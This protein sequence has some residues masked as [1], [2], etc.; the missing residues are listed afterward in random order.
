ML[1][2]VY[3]RGYQ[4]QLKD[5]SFEKHPPIIVDFNKMTNKSLT[6]ASDDEIKRSN[7]I[8]LSGENCKLWIETR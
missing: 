8:E 2:Q 4:V 7:M 1:I 6:T 5:I 3:A